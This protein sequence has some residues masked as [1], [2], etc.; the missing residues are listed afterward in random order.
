MSRGAR[1]SDTVGDIVS[2]WNLCDAGRNRA[3]CAWTRIAR[4]RVL[5]VG[6]DARRAKI[7][8]LEIHKSKRR[9]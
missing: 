1:R 7:A 2:K 5:R 8:D 9:K 4:L 6:E 3:T